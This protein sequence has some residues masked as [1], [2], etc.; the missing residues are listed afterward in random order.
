MRER[1]EQFFPAEL[2]QARYHQPDLKQRASPLVLV[3]VHHASVDVHTAG[4]KNQRQ[5]E[6]Y[7]DRKY[8]Y[9]VIRDLR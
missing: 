7:R 9:K 5:R 6:G 8:Y 2:Q 4:L 1:F 3:D